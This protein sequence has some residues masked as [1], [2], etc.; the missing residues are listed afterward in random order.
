MVVLIQCFTLHRLVYY[1]QLDLIFG[2]LKLHNLFVHIY[3]GTSCFHE[4]RLVNYITNE[5]CSKD[6]HKEANGG[7]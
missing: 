3:D 6:S 5:R 1:F 7:R 2:L 4:K